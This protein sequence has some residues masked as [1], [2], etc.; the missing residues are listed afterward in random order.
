MNARGLTFLMAVGLAGSAAVAGAQPV[1]SAPSV[2]VQWPSSTN[3]I[4]EMCLYTPSQSSGTNGS[5]IE[6]RD[7][8]YNGHQVFKRAH[9]PIL[10]VK[11]VPGS[12]CDCYR[13]WSD[14]EAKFEIRDSNNNVVNMSGTGHY[15]ETSVPPRTVCD[16]GVT[17]VDIPS[18][19]GFKGV[20]AEKLP[21]RLILTTQM[22]A[23]WYRYQMKYYFYQDGRIE[24]RFGFGAVNTSSCL[25]NTHRH[26]NYWR[27]DFDI[28][29]PGNDAIGNPPAPGSAFRVVD[30]EDMRNLPD[31]IKKPPYIVHDTVTGRGYFLNPGPE[32]VD[33]PADSF[34][35]GDS[36]MLKYSSNQSTA[37]T[38]QIDDG[39]GLG[40]CPLS[41]TFLNFDNNE[42]INGADVVVWYR[43]G[44]LHLGGDLDGCTWVGPTLQPVGDWSPTP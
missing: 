20:A 35:I 38:A 24:P 44:G 17:S 23:G 28:D 13:D 7:V 4:W 33:L 34:S 22:Q 36:W 41:S 31:A 3:R 29:G 26:H 6:L 9:S 12:N 40:G 19:T 16:A 27:F 42:L 25:Q 15:F 30:Q 32:N 5:A 21:D 2:L 14:E 39:Q 8:R 18:T 43:G 37:V 1:C 10:N 11:Y